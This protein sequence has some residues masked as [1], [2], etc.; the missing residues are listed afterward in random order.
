[1]KITIMNP[2]GK[3]HEL[4]SDGYLTHLSEDFY[5]GIIYT[6]EPTVEIN[7]E[8]FLAD[9]VRT[10]ETGD[11]FK[12]NDVQFTYIVGEDGNPYFAIEPDKFTEQTVLYANKETR[13]VFDDTELTFNLIKAEV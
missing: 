3:I 9:D 13:L 5:N 7:G 11:T 12:W 2:D 10:L 8:N 6:D 4:L 1:M